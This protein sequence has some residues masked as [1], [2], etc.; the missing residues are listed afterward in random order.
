MWAWPVL[1]CS[2]IHGVKNRSKNSAVWP[3]NLNEVIFLY[4]LPRAMLS[5]APLGLVAYSHSAYSA[6]VV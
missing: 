6:S 3:L 2:E 5:P 1:V 4:V